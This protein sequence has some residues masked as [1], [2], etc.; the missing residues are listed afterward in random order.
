M[1]TL[2][3]LFGG[4]NSGDEEF[5]QGDTVMVKFNLKVETVISKKGDY[6]VV[7]LKRDNGE[8]YY[9]SYYAN[10]LSKY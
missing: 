9:E 3:M 5:S 7:K 6:Y 8:E 2:D 1:G 10:E 4:N